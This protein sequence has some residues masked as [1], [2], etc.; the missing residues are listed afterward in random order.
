MDLV[1]ASLPSG[2]ASSWCVT[3]QPLRT[4]TKSSWASV[5][6]T[7]CRQEPAS[8]RVLQVGLRTNYTS[9]RGLAGADAD[10]DVSLADADGGVAVGWSLGQSGL[11]I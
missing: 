5:T 2:F 10:L 7:R 11:S 1:Q 8:F 3:H 6:Y 4:S 9:P